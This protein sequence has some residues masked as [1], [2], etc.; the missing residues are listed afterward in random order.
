MRGSRFE[1]KPLRPRFSWDPPQEEVPADRGPGEASTSG[2]DHLPLHTGY[3]PEEFF[4]DRQRVWILCG[5]A[6]SGADLSVESGMNVYNI[7]KDQ[8]DLIVRLPHHVIFK[9]SSWYM[10]NKKRHS[11]AF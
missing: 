9:H 4:G 5:G 7:L 6:G 2:E 10:K 3:H 8:M 11:A 1:K